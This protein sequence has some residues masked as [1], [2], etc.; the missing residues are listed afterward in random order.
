MIKRTS[1]LSELKAEL[2][3]NAEFAREYYK[4]SPYNEL[5]VQAI[6]RRHEVNITQVEIAKRMKTKQSAVSR[7]FNDT[8]NPRLKTIVGLADAMDCYI[9]LKFTPYP[10]NALSPDPP[11]E[12]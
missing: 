3:K 9:E 8:S 1:S 11:G 10:A 6:N 5:L 2:M 4:Q 7:L 12:E